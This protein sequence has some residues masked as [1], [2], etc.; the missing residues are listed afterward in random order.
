MRRTTFPF[1]FLIAILAV[2]AVRGDAPRR[3]ENVIIVTLDGFRWQEVFAGAD[4]TLMDVKSGGV[5][6][7]AEL[8]R[9]FWRATAEERRKVLLPFFWGTLARRGQVFGDPARNA[10]ARLTNGMKFSY[11]GYNEIFCGFGDKRIDSN[12]KKNNPNLSVLEFLNDKPAL[13]NK[14]A[15]FCTW[16][17]FPYI[18]RAATNG[19]KVHAGWTSIADKPLS[20]RQRL[21]NEMMANLPHY[22]LDNGFDTIT[23]EASREHLR[24]HKPRVLYI[25]LGETDEWGHGRRYDLYL[26]AAYNADLFLAGLWDMIQAMPDYKDKTALI[27]TT[28][29]GRGLTRIDWTDHGEKVPGAEFIWIAAMG[30]DTA[31]LGV[32]RNTTVTQG[33]VAATIA[34]LLGEDFQAA[35]PRAAPPLPDIDAKLNS[36]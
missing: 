18:F 5:R 30:P 9:R 35:V 4:E 20:A 23:M 21:T 13:R 24:R 22:W 34:R 32:R 31:A 12:A 6:D 14:V 27:V 8:K 28:D 2:T 17:V 33:Q 3:T 16:E 10:A 19:L 1:A 36:R 29:H 7:V 25:G 15:A 26:G 11:P